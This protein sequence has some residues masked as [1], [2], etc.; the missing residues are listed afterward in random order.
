MK[1]EKDR[2]GR[3]ERMIVTGLITNRA[4]LGAV[5][6]LWDGKLFQSRW[7]NEVAGWC[8]EHYRRFRKPP[9]TKIQSLFDR[10]AVKNSKDKDTVG[11]V[12][13]FLEGLSRGYASRKK[14]VDAEY[15]ID[16]AKEFF[17]RVRLDALKEEIVGLVADGD[18]KEAWRRVGAARR[19]ELGT[20]SVINPFANAAAVSRA[21]AAKSDPLITYPDALGQFF[22]DSLEREGFIAVHAP[23]KRGKS[24]ILLEMAFRAMQL[25]R[26]VAMFQLGDLSQAQFLRRLY[27]RVC[28]RPFKATE[29]GRVVRIPN[30]LA[31]PTTP[32]GL[33]DVRHNERRWDRDLSVGLA[34]KKAKRILKKYGPDPF[35]LSCHPARTLSV[36]G[37]A[38]LLDR[39]EA[40]GWKADV[41]VYDYAELFAGDG[42][43]AADARESINAN[44]IGMASLRL[45]KH[46]L[47]LTAT[48]T[49]AD[50]Y[51]ADLI[52][53]G[54][55]SEDKRKHS[56]VTGS[57]ALNQSDEEKELGLYRLNWLTGRD[58]E[59]STKKAVYVAGCAALQSPFMLST[60]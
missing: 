16:L 51:D 36:A 30:Y 48:Q 53:M 29:E 5:A 22:G 26:R 47:I 20:G 40:D 50:S 37:S 2:N 56:H 3:N 13:S 55:F 34:A 59:Y 39:W 45:A 60:F 52:G 33:P 18:V 58:W 57:F 31:P 15:T 7:A 4:V 1:V 12:G 46:Y 10:W 43:S 23:E 25:G 27:A 9:G 32:D 8:V 11:L 28:R 14:E 17:D 6:A 35:R 41:V 49:N 44:W 38:E 54:N 19:V 42:K 24:T 21:F